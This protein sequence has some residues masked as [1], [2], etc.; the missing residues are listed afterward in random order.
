MRGRCRGL[1][2][3]RK[4][5]LVPLVSVLL[6]VRNGER[7]LDAA[8]ASIV[9]QTHAD[10]EVLVVDDGSVDSTAAVAQAWA[11][12]DRRVRVLTLDRPLGVAGALDVALA[13][14]AGPLVARMDADDLSHPRR[15]ERQ[16][17]FLS[18]HPLVAA[19]GTATRHIDV[20]GR[21]LPSLLTTVPLHPLGVRVCTAVSTPM[22]HP[23]VVAR[24]AVLRERG[25][26]DPDAVLE[27]LDL[28][29]RCADLELANLPEVLLSYRVHGA[30][31]TSGARSRGAE[32]LARPLAEH[33]ADLLGEAVPAATCRLLLDPRSAASAAD[34]AVA[35]G[36]E[37]LDRLVG[38]AGPDA[39]A[40]LDRALS[41]AAVL[42]A[43]RARAG[44]H[45][46]RS[47]GG[48]QLTVTRLARRVARGAWVSGRRALANRQGVP[49]SR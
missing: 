36:F 46:P 49:L 1:R 14:A 18:E 8:L 3:V 29:L 24:T 7:L 38:L 10:L 17:A 37:V 48:G 27:D 16:V 45:T 20:R 28:W 39:P 31:T 22:A 13:E 9:A 11:G 15:L 44:L 35:Q 26:Y 40:V 12:R 5:G 21:P 19:C 47:Y 25:G 23:T 2:D 32:Q 34:G 33:L 42:H 41:T 4:T 43:T 6:P 30:N